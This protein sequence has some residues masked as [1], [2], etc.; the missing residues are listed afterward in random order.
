[1]RASVGPRFFIKIE[2]TK[3]HRDMPIRIVDPS[4]RAGWEPDT[5]ITDSLLRRFLVN[6]TTS[7]EASGIPLGARTLRRDDVAAVDL[8]RPSVGSNVVTLLV[9]LFPE[10]VGEIMATLD[11]FYAFA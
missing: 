8:G 9:P 5:P 6:W 3:E 4:L 1:M 2:C 10:D 11:E 7:I